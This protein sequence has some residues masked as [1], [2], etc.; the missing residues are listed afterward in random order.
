MWNSNTIFILR[1]LQEKYSAKKKN[2]YFEDLEKVFD[3]V[4]RDVIW[5]ALSK[6]GVEEGLV[7]IVQ[8]MYR[9]IQI[10]VIVKWSCTY[11]FLV[12]VGLHQG[13]LL[14]LCYLS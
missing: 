1:Q 10:R 14:I 8:S 4:P 11:D 3:R 5:W 7:K 12:Q 9:N 13:S 2:L 6:L